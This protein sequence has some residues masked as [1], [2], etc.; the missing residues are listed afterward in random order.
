MSRK[1]IVNDGRHE[2]ELLLVGT[3][4]VGRD[5]TCDISDADPLLSRRHVEFISGNNEVTVRD[6]GSRN[7]IL[8]N[9]VKIAQ[10]VLRGGD[11]VQIG[12]LQVRFIDDPTRADGLT[13]DADETALASPPPQRP[14]P[15]MPGK[16]STFTDEPTER[17]ARPLFTDQRATAEADGD[18]TIP[19]IPPAPNLA[20][21]AID[22]DR[23]QAPPKL[24][25]ADAADVEHA[26]PDKTRSAAPPP[27]STIESVSQPTQTVTS[28]DRELPR[29]VRQP[30]TS[31]FLTPIAALAA[32]VFLATAIPLT[33]WA[34]SG[35]GVWAVP[36]VVTAAGVWFTSRLI[37]RRF[38][39]ALT[40]CED[41]SR[42]SDSA[43]A[44]GT[45]E[46]TPSSV[47]TKERGF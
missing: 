11:V 10:S 35:A 41:K 23:T 21:P 4:V 17:V 7:G 16:A 34:E 31:F 38:T 28:L 19:A 22:L 42:G 25:K 46:L 37:D 20:A 15:A 30:E 14:R 27:V 6:L 36:V 29:V 43:V 12:H 9:G 8:I 40:A 1:L 44:R 47:R 18:R 3:I 24:S 13:R 32:A 39:A 26:D 5:P 45:P 2:R 33:L